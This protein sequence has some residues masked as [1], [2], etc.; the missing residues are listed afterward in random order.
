MTVPSVVTARRLAK[1]DRDRFE[2][3]GDDFHERVH[4]SF[5]KMAAADP[6]R[7]VVIDALQSIDTVEAEVWAA[8]E[9]KLAT[10]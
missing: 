2:M 8:V 6:D 7:W 3:A 4:R 10:T 5:V 1:R 9:P